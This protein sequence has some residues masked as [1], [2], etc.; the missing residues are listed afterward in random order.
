MLYR[1]IQ[2]RLE[3][4]FT[5]GSNKILLIDGARQIGKSFIVRHMGQKHFKN[6]IEVNLWEDSLNS[7]LFADVK[8]VDDFYLRLSMFAGNKMGDAK[9]TLVFLDEI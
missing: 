5:A 7:R 6:Y 8:N 4:Y 9:D 2:R 3:E 1:K